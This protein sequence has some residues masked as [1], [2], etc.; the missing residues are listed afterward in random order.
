M[1]EKILTFFRE[2]KHKF[3]KTI[4]VICCDN[5]REKMALATICKREG[6]GI[7]FEFTAPGKASSKNRFLGISLAIKTSKIVLDN[8]I[9]SKMFRILN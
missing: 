3:S 5:A 2:L 4:T 7:G 6:L 9:Y 8:T 1:V